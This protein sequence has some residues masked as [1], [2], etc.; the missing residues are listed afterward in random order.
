MSNRGY[1][2]VPKI[3][4]LFASGLIVSDPCLGTVK[5][6]GYLTYFDQVSLF[7]FCSLFKYWLFMEQTLDRS[8]LLYGCTTWLLT[9]K[10]DGN[11]TR[12]LLNYFLQILEPTPQE[13]AVW[14]LTS[15]LKNHP[16]KGNKTC[17]TLLEKQ[18][19][20][21]KGCSSTHGY[22]REGMLVGKPESDEW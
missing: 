22:A 15:N 4:S 5:P 19:Q 21:H 11:Y 9:K 16:S 1:M 3:L 12:M 8:I 7:L 20:T 13:T 6:C 14:V 18:G 10:L 17:S 2:T